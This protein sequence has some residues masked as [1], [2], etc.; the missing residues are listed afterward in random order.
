LSLAG[1]AARFAAAAAIALRF[2]N[3]LSAAARSE[4]TH[5]ETSHSDKSL[6]ER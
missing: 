1:Q 5:S 3:D 6:A 4:K 2:E